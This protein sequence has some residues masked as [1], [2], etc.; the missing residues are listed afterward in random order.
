MP[1]ALDVTLDDGMH[2]HAA[3]EDYHGFHTNPLDWRAARQK[4]DR[5]TRAFMAPAARDALA[6][7]IATLDGREVSDL[8]S[9]LGRVHA[10]THAHV[11][12]AHRRARAG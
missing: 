10:H 6:D 8:T 5:L 9:R 12:E 7:V 3:R 11:G 4:F 1:A 2:F